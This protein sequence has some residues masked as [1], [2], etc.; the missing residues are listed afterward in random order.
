M[1]EFGGGGGAF[2]R[3]FGK[4]DRGNRGK[5]L[6]FGLFCLFVFLPDV[7][8]QTRFIGKPCY[9]KIRQKTL[10]SVLPFICFVGLPPL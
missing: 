5:V 7:W 10:Q 4:S 2:G 3:S 9:K 1:R 6:V 8:R